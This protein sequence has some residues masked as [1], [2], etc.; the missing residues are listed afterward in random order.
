MGLEASYREYTKKVKIN[1]IIKKYD[2]NKTG[3][4]EKEQFIKLMTDIDDFSPKGQPPTDEQVEFVLRTADKAGDGAINADEL[5]EALAC[6][7]TFT[8]HRAEFEEKLA[9][10]DASGTGKLS[11]EELKAYLVD[12][13]GGKDVTDEEVDLVFKDADVL[14]DG[15]L[16]KIEL[17]RA[18][19][20]WYSYV[21]KN[22]GC[23]SIS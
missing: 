18:T 7:T 20:L 2:T 12:L 13:N 9:K 16:N 6:W 5:E 10:Y 3:K 15:Q 1:K 17:Q 21:E 14:G 22:K 4:L 19:A 23:C 8:E 11:K